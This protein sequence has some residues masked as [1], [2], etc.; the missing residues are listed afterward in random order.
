MILF[1]IITG[2]FIWIVSNRIGGKKVKVGGITVEVL[3][4]NIADILPKVCK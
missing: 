1:H 3:D 2:K 4:K